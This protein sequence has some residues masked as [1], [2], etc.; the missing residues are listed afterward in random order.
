M[1]DDFEKD[2]DRGVTASINELY[3]YPDW[4]AVYREREILRKKCSEVWKN[5]STKEYL[6]ALYVKY[7]KR[8]KRKINIIKHIIQVRF[9]KQ[10]YKK[11]KVNV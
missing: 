7:G 5:P 3:F 1:I 11:S 9:L 2:I 10:D 4:N 6:Q 8:I